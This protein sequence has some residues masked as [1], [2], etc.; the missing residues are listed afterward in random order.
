[1]TQLNPYLN[2]DG[3]TEEAFNLYKSVFGGEFTDFTRFKDMP[4]AAEL[5][6]EENE[7]I[8]HVSLKI[9]DNIL[10]GTDALPKQ[11]RTV[12]MGTNVSLSIEA[13][14]KEAAEELYAKLSAG[15]V[16]DMPMA[17]MFWD[18]YFGILTDKFGIK[19]MINCNNKK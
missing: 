2:L 13:D 3:T 6:P 7:K 12:T 11:G 4:E 10:M 17:D 16:K 1:M 18:A 14:T 5:S 8:M 9:G 15:G 19:W